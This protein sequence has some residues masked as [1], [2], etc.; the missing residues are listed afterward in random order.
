M[1][2][3]LR[4]E[5]LTGEKLTGE[6]LSATSLCGDSRPRLS[7]ERSSMLFVAPSTAVSH[8]RQAPT[9]GNLFGL[10]F[11]LEGRGSYANLSQRIYA[12]RQAAAGRAGISDCVFRDD[13]DVHGV[14]C[15]NVRTGAKCVPLM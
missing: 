5:K 1:W 12:Q 3:K 2:D 11:V 13:H 14:S 4:G 10:P 8:Y 9:L 15:S 6:K 7:I